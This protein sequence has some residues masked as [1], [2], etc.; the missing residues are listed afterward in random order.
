MIVAAS[1]LEIKIADL[2]PDIIKK[3]VGEYQ[4]DRNRRTKKQ[5]TNDVASYQENG[6]PYMRSHQSQYKVIQE[7]YCRLPKMQISVLIHDLSNRLLHLLFL[8]SL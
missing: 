4:S 6:G 3:Y 8:S 5:V 7:S 1:V 2:L